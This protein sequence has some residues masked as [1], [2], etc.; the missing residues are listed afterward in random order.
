M[1]KHNSN[2]KG[3]A[4][5]RFA[6]TPL[7]TAVVVAMNPGSA[8]LAQDDR[9][10]SGIEEIIVTATKRTVSIQDVA[11]SITAFSTAEIA[12]R[13]ILD[14]ADIA[15]NL[16]SISNSTSRAGRNELVYRGISSGNSWRLASQVAVYL[17]DQPMTSA[18]TQLDPRMVDIERVE[19]LPGPQGTLF[20][21]SS[22][23]G[24]LRIITN[25]PNFDR[26]S[27]QMNV[28][29]KQT[30]DGEDSYDINAHLNIPVSDSFA[31]RIVAFSAKEGGYIDNV[32]ST[33]PHYECVAGADCE[34]FVAAGPI[35]STT[36]DN[37]GLVEDDYNDYTIAGARVSALWNINE[38]WD[39]LATVMHQDSET[40]GVWESDMGIGDFKVARFSDEWR[41]D[42][43]TT[44]A[45]TVKGD[46][47]FAEFSNSFAYADREQQYSFDNT[48]YE[49]WHTTY[50][51][52]WGN[53]YDYMEYYDIFDTGMNGGVY[54]S[55]QDAERITNELRLTSQGDSRYQW[56]IGAFYEDN[57]DGWLDQAHIPNLDSTGSWEYAQWQACEHNANGYDYIACPLPPA[58]NIW[59]QDVYD[60]NVVQIAAFGELGY[61]FTDKL[62]VTVGMRWFQY[63]T[64]VVMNRQWPLGLP[65]YDAVIAGFGAGGLEEG[66][67]SDTAL[68]LAMK[69][70]IDDDRM[71]YAQFSQGFRLGGQNDGKSVRHGF[72]DETYDPDKVDNYEVG[73]KSEWLD[74]RLQI[75]ASVFLMEWK[76]VQ[77][78]IRADNFWW[79]S[80]TV[81]GG[82][83][84]NLGGEFDVTWAA[85]DNLRLSA[86]AY[87][88]DAH[89]T[90]DYVTNEGNTELYAGTSMIDA[91]SK[92][93]SFA[94]DYT[95]PQLFGNWDLNMRWDYRY[96][97]PLY[98]TWDA[99]EEGVYNVDDFTMQNFQLGINNGDD[100]SVS[101]M[102]R[103]LTDE[104][105]NTF[106]N[107]GDSWYGNFWG[108]TGFGD[109]QNLA[110]P[111]TISFRVEKKF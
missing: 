85:T 87:F 28:E 47:G 68:K 18:T 10:N 61:D 102:V 6:M 37:A 74:N 73:I 99:A 98:S 39:L 32:A 5:R 16:P 76:E 78:S 62:N 8:A 60:R 24:T 93:Y 27:G 101:L 105:A 54:K 51:G 95:I 48:H 110:K 23:T 2:S 80:G 56:M 96:R 22:Q 108:H 4:I 44:Y 79:L 69:Y 34:G 38:D 42:K 82:G 14:M 107:D 33:A 66:K 49:A 90:D 1:S 29:L 15:S 45:F 65:I 25:K 26:F 75:N 72:V 41:T 92:K 109:Y 67:E 46:L 36:P 19:S 21:S 71:V 103:N 64:H 58:N 12:R 52:Y 3:P 13:G 97:G 106:T 35:D 89:Y 83:G 17:D 9:E 86:A 63:D 55:L 84:E 59:Y 77:L 30:K 104:R 94:A 40:T 111:R 11:Q 81:N 43:W 53:Y 88:G 31:M 57:T 91:A 70:S 100:W 50:Y 7:A 20:G